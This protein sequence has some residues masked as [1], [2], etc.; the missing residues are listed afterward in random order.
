[1]LHE[2]ELLAIQSFL[3]PEDLMKDLRK[4]ADSRTE[5]RNQVLAALTEM[6][7][8][9]RTVKKVLSL[10]LLAIRPSSIET[11]LVWGLLYL[12]AEVSALF[13]DT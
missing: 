9:L 8:G 1:M 2:H 6:E 4:Q 12:V 11:G 13:N 3:A 5:G 7:S 10:L